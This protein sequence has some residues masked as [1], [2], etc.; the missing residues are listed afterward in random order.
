MVPLDTLV[1]KYGATHF[2]TALACFIALTC[3]QLE[4]KLW[5]VCIPFSKLPV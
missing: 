4:R 3:A 1:T 2:H 5:G